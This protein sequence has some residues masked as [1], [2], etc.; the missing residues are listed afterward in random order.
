MR[1]FIALTLPTEVQSGL[2]RFI[3]TLKPAAVGTI[4]WVKPANLHL[5]VKFLGEV[6][7]Q[8]AKQVLDAVGQVAND[9]LPFTFSIQGSGVFTDSKHPRVLWV[10][11]QSAEPIVLLS[12][13]LDKSLQTL[14]FSPEGRPFNPHLTLGR[15]NDGVSETHL[16]GLMTQFLQ[17][18]NRLFGS[19][20]AEEL[21][22][23][24]S[25]LRPEGP[26]YTTWASCRFSSA[27]K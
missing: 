25:D 18:E 2:S 8:N 23:I 21:H 11:V 4:R 26:I 15:V 24:K 6:R 17:T 3:E 7:E 16:K 14:G 10:G 5:T 9:T 13:R 22:I 1:L 19:I 27:T 20:H 12:K